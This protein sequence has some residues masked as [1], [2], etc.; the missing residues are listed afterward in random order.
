MARTF[1]SLIQIDGTRTVTTVDGRAVIVP[2]EPVYQWPA[3]QSA[4]AW[5]M[6][7]EARRLPRPASRPLGG[8]QFQERLPPP[9]MPPELAR[10]QRWQPSAYEGAV[11]TVLTSVFSS[12]TG[13]CLRGVLLNQ[14]VTI[15][16]FPQRD[17]VH[18]GTYLANAAPRRIAAGGQLY[19]IYTPGHFPQRFRGSSLLHEFVHIYR[20]MLR[21][22]NYGTPVRDTGNDT[23]RAANL[24]E[25]YTCLEEWIAICIENIF[26][27][28]CSLPLRWG[29]H[30]VFT[31]RLDQPDRWMRKRHNRATLRQVAR[32]MC[33]LVPSLAQLN[34][35]FN[36]FHPNSPGYE[37]MD[38]E[39]PAAAHSQPS[40]A[41][42]TGATTTS[43]TATAS[44]RPA[45]RPS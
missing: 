23:E 7:E 8:S 36:P 31:N 24:R 15:V 38:Q 27:S 45:A 6:H 4:P 37:L 11:H 29:H 34:T 40:T 26:R 21:V 18:Q 3:G 39:C 30:D 17:P 13:S 28:E 16:P 22:W 20:I 10:I 14:P 33:S 19:I 2:A 5:P 41:A 1:D 12:R 32:Q 25:R 43:S 9:P 42:T 44:S 35:S